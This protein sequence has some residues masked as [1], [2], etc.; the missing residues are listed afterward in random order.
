MEQIHYRGEDAFTARIPGM[1][2][3]MFLLVLRH[4]RVVTGRAPAELLS[5]AFFADNNLRVDDSSRTSIV[6]SCP[7]CWS[8]RQADLVETTDDRSSNRCFA[9]PRDSWGASTVR[10][11]PTLDDQAQSP[12][13]RR[14][15]QRGMLHTSRNWDSSVAYERDVRGVAR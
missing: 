6:A 8:H 10:R 5:P 4:Q 14:T 3:A 15:Q 1:A 12:L 11:R 13:T 7:E 9:L 2:R